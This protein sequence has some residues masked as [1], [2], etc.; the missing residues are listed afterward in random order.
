MPISR[1]P[2]TLPLAVAALTV[3]IAVAV[4]FVQFTWHDGSDASSAAPLPTACENF[5][6]ASELFAQGG[7]A[8]ALPMTG[9][10]VFTRDTQA[11]SKQIL[12]DLMDSC[13]AE[14]G[15]R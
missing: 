7:S 14:R 2:W 4:L 10:R 1:R 3:A 8:E 15:Q 6:K 11:D 5:A 9:G 12:R 13:D